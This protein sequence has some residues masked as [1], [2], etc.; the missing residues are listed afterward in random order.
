MNPIIVIELVCVGII[1]GMT[2]S[3]W[4]NNTNEYLTDIVLGI[5]NSEEP[6]IFPTGRYYN[7]IHHDYS[8]KEKDISLE[9][10][11]KDIAALCEKTDEEISE[12]TIPH[13]SPRNFYNTANFIIKVERPYSE[14]KNSK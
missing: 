5:D 9:K 6:N 4:I 2:I 7:P 3:T 13:N 11:E 8:V 12:Q 10:F 14:D 1:L